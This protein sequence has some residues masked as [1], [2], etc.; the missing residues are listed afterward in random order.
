LQPS[1]RTT[2]AGAVVSF[3]VTASGI[4]PLQFQWFKDFTPLSSGE[5]VSGATGATLSLSNLLVT[6]SGGYAAEVTDASGSVT[7]STALLT[8]QYPLADPLNPGPNYWVG[9]I[10]WQPD[11]KI[12]LG[13]TF[14]NVAGQSRRNLARL[15]SDGTL[16]ASFTPAVGDPNNHWVLALALQ[17][18]GKILVGGVFTNLCGQYRSG[19]GRLNADGTLDAAFNVGANSYINPIALQADGKI[20]IAG[21]FNT[22]LGQTR[23]YIGRVNAD[24]TLDIGFNPGVNSPPDTIVVQPDGKIIVGGNFTLLAGQGR[25]RLGRLNANGSLDVSFNPGANDRVQAIALQPDGKI[26]VGGTF[27]N[28]AGQRRDFLGRLNSNGDLDTTF[29]PGCNNWVQSIVLQADGKIIV[30]GNFTM[31][32]TQSR[33]RIGRLNSDG[34]VDPTF[35][36][37]ANNGVYSLGIQPDGRILVGGVFTTLGG[38]SRTSFGRLNN[39]D[40]ALENIVFDG[41]SLSWFRG[42]TAPEIW[43]PTMDSW[44]GG[45][46]SPTAGN[47]SR[48]AG[49]WGITGLPFDTNTTIRLRGRVLSG[50]YNDSSGVVES[51]AGPIMMT[52]QP[53]SR[54]NYEGTVAKFAVTALG[55]SPITYQWFKASTP[56]IDGGS[57]SGSTNS[58]LTL[59]NVLPSDAGDY[60]AVISNPFGVI[61]SSVATLTVW[62]AAPDTFNP[63]PNNWVHTVAFQPDGKVLVGGQFTNLCGQRRD[64][65]AR[66]NRDGTLDTAFDPGVANGTVYAIAVQPSG[67]ILVGGSFT[68]LGGQSRNYIGCLNPDGTLDS[69]FNPGANSWINAFALLPSGKILAGGNF[70]NLAGLSRRYLAR[71][72]PD[73]TLD[74]PFN[75]DPNGAVN[76]FGLQTDGKI[77]VGGTFR[78]FGGQNRTNLARLNADDTVDS[79]FNPGASGS[80]FAFAVQPSGKIVVG[81]GFSTLGGLARVRIGRLNADGTGDAT[82]NPGA[83]GDVFSLVQQADGKILVG[84]QFATLAGA[85]RTNLGRLLPDGLLDTTFKPNANG[86]VFTLGL[87]PDGGILAGGGFTVLGGQNRSYL[88]RLINTDPALQ[89]VAFNGT[90]LTWQRGGAAPDFIRT[91]VDVW[92][93]GSWNSVT[94][95]TRYAGGWQNLGLS[96]S[97]QSILRLH[98]YVAGGYLNGSA[99]ME[100]AFVQPPQDIHAV[101]VGGA[102][103]IQFNGIPNYPWVLQSATN[104]APPVD[105]QSI[106][107]NP[108]DPDGQWRTTLTNT[109]DVPVRFYRTLRP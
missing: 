94:N 18:D 27:T 91:T 102:L 59:T 25:S 92:Q 55:G 67:K 57:I 87:Q 51:F 2:N 7:S 71:L 80:V 62:Y 28:L 82:F 42:G 3:S 24:G 70:T 1:S 44:Q 47:L 16:D 20:I 31:L 53:S 96:L 19:I 5:R 85:S 95:L 10:A 108:T 52:S 37:G 29:N 103:E 32:G 109:F 105:W 63:S 8:V 73:G 38:Q 79:T 23:I 106:L 26:L 58:A 93:G 88:G 75:P 13:G 104:L 100:E 34:S 33:F 69:S 6:D 99:S 39:T 30:A 84:G 9:G 107:T 61:T 60:F 12:L 56:L 76:T 45:Q 97:P 101:V 68:N 36:P 22:L 11:G 81:G 35:N 43:S 41:T 74:I 40:P 50:Q 21:A 17:P 49:G 54:T 14:T 65:I 89:G 78:V 86:F 90:N 66:L 72:N 48:I 77:L 4:N 83:G 98:G 15:N 46:W 64:R